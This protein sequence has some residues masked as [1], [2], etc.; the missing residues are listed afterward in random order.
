MFLLGQYNTRYSL[1]LSVKKKVIK[2]LANLPL[3]D[4][5]L[6]VMRMNSKDTQA[7]YEV[8]PLSLSDQQIFH[9]Q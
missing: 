1:F 3:H 2:L 4:I 7:E 8:T 5:F 9:I 6:Y